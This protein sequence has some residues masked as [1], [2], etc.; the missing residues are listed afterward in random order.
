M[1]G[2]HR[3]L[4]G[5][6]FEQTLGDSGGQRSL[7]SMCS[8]SRTRLGHRTTTATTYFPLVVPQ[9]LLGFGLEI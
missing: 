6:E 7:Q 4:N 9:M 1:V 2:W 8:Q 5:H 3:R